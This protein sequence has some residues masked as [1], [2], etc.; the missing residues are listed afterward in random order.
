MT[1][2][3]DSA[4]WYLVLLA[5]TWGLAPLV[6]LLCPRLPDKGAT[7]ARPLALL[8]VVYPTWLLS[9]LKLLPYSTAGLWA[10]L[11]VAAIA[12]WGVLIWRR[13]VTRDWLRGLLIAEAVALVAFAAYI[14]LRGYTPQILNTE[15]PM[16]EAFLAS[17]A[18]AVAMPPRDPWFAG[19]PINYYYLGYLLHGALTRMAAVPAS[20]G[21]NL[22]L[23]TTFS[24]TVTAAAGIGYNVA[25]AWLGRSQAIAAGVLTALFLA[26]VGNLYAAIRLM[27]H[28]GLTLHAQWWGDPNNIGWNS[29][30][31]VCMVPSALGACPANDVTIN[32]F[33]YFSFLLGDLHPHVVALPFT[34]VALA[35]ALNLLLLMRRQGGPHMTWGDWATI[36]VSGAAVGALYAMNSWDYPTYLAIAAVALWI[37]LAWAPVRRRWISLGVLAAAGVVAWAPFIVTFVPFAGGNVAELPAALQHV[38]LLTKV[39]TTL[40]VVT[41][42]RTTAVEFLTIFGIAYA[43]ALALI[44]PGLVATRV[45]APQRIGQATAFAVAVTVVLAIVLTAPLVVIC[46]APLLGAVI[47]LRRR[48]EV[49]PRTIALA[50]FAAGLA[51]ILL[52]EFFYIQDVFQDRM[53]TLF[54]VY[55]QAWTLFALGIALTVV[56]LWREVRPVAFLRPALATVVALALAAGFVY[57]ALASYQWVEQIGTGGAWQGLDGLA[58]IEQGHP[59]EAAAIKWLR[60][61]AT[62]TDVLLEAAGCSYGP[63]GEMPYDS[64]AAFTGVPTVIGWTGHEQ[65]WRSGQPALYAQI[66]QRAN[67]VPQMYANPNG[68]LIQKYHV[69]LLYV[70]QYEQQK[71]PDGC[72][73]AGPYPGVAQGG[74]PGAG[75]QEVFKQGDVR[76]YRKR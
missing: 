17:S 49:N 2:L 19:Q 68:E 67:D 31:I 21:F 12:G 32:E 63:I 3:D 53:N 16:D 9:S 75:W 56:I 72:S 22:A 50:L 37:G 42:Q 64:V 38:P 24:M 39:L 48:P 47:L 15:K 70:G 74:S 66:E 45:V 5:A 18:R 55:Y 52:T 54:K 10:T 61:H 43:A 59:D 41:G 4:K 57:P 20:V 13:Q 11:A 26:I 23:A 46:G 58:Y 1:W 28:P 8:A 65:Q 51:L 30:R 71:G 76:I 25:R 34:L 33:P 7:I 6:R 73:V 14:W 36:A 62:T 44:V 40:G 27:G 35:L 69:T 60:A 29:S